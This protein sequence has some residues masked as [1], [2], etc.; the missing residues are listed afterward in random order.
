MC[1]FV[2]LGDKEGQITS[3][4]SALAHL[5][6]HTLDGLRDPPTRRSI[7]GHC[8]SEGALIMMDLTFLGSSSDGN[9]NN[10]LENTKAGFPYI[11]GPIQCGYFKKVLLCALWFA[12]GIDFLYADGVLSILVP[13]LFLVHGTL[14]SMSKVLSKCSSK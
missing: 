9:K 1:D 5:Y 13:A 7:V 4:W 3:R 6:L 14:P 8:G 10:G 11:S 2:V 12:S